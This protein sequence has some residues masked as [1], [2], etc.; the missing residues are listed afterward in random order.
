MCLHGFTDTWRTW[1]LVL[2]ALERRHDVLALT[3][4]GHAGGPPLPRELSHP[5]LVDAIEQAL[6]GAGIER[7]H[8]AGN[9]LG[10]YLALHLAAR[11]RAASV[12]AF[13]PAGGWAVGDDSWRDLLAF[14]A[15][16]PA[17]AA[18]SAPQAAQL[19]RC[20]RFRR[21]AT[22]LIVERSDHIPGELVAHQLLGVALCA[23]AQPLI[24]HALRAGY[25]LEPERI[26][27]PVRI[28]WGTADRLLPW[29]RPPRATGASGCPT[30]TGSSST[31][32]GTARSSTSRSRRRS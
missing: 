26:E 17:Q 7:A 15:S 13:A 11:G 5:A 32:S 18:R 6:D 8:L 23:G 29:P 30:Q 2:P 24:E 21:A 1:E 14:Q 16:L 19:A 20:A 28:V 25:S 22:K 27:C 9:S 31:A 4:P 12:V 10:A 3:L